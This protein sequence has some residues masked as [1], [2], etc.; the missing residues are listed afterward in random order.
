MTSEEL[1]RAVLTDENTELYDV[2]RIDNLIKNL[3]L[4]YGRLNIKNDLI[5]ISHPAGKAKRIT[6]FI[7]KDLLT[8]EQLTSVELLKK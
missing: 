1:V 4:G 5:T 6:Y 3:I 7:S 8:K 2:V